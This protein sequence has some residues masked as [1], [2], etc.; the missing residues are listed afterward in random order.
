MPH[1][2]LFSVLAIVSGCNSYRGIV[3]FTDVHRRRLNA[4]FG[5]GLSD[6][7][8]LATKPRPKRTRRPAS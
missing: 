8:A 6:A 4:V 3:T 2:L 1:V 7:D 5:L